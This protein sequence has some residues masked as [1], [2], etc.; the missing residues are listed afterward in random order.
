MRRNAGGKG[1]RDT[2]N[3]YRARRIWTAALARVCRSRSV[4]LGYH[5]VA[6]C[7]SRDDLFLLQLS[8]AK[9]RAQLELMLEAGFRFTTVAEL[10]REAVGGPVPPGPS[11]S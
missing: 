8:P 1:E 4:I 6:N 9:F 3:P 2:P 11:L 10:A 5:G 7:S